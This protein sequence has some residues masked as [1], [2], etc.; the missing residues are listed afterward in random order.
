MSFDV[1][2]SLQMSIFRPKRRR[3][4]SK[5]YTPD[6]LSRAQATASAWRQSNSLSRKHPLCARPLGEKDENNTVPDKKQSPESA[7]KWSF[8]PWARS[9]LKQV[10]E[11]RE[12]C[13]Y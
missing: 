3:G 7:L 11:G 1:T 2:P 4:L 10:E 5:R 9:L 12:S 8:L 6:S 13:I